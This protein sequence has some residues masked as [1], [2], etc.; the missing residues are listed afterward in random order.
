MKPNVLITSI[1]AKIPL[2]KQV[3]SALERNGHFGRIIGADADEN[4]I[5]AYFVDEFWLMEP[6]C[7]WE[8]STFVSS[9]KERNIHAIIPTREGD[10]PFFSEHLMTLRAHE[11]YTMVSAQEAVQVCMDKWHFYEKVISWGIPVIPTYRSVDEAGRNRIVIKE[12]RGS[13]SRGVTVNVDAA[14]ALTYVAKMS[15]PLIQPF[16]SGKEFSIDLYVDCVGEVKGVVVRERVLVVRGES[17][18]SRTLSHPLLEELCIRLV[19][20]LG[21]YGHAVVQAFEQE[22]GT[23]LIIECNARFGGASTLGIRAGVDSFYWFLLE[24]RGESLASLPVIKC[25]Q[26]VTMVRHNEDIWL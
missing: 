23:V 7:A 1:A 14:E 3:R 13:G 17:Q 25:N 22:D 9:C 12:R 26:T 21:I 24:S 4:V 19:K 15:D 8:I 11:I 20:K 6:I 18:I 16:I 10:L 2:I 5:G